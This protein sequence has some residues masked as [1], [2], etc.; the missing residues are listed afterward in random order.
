MLVLWQPFQISW[1][2]AHGLQKAGL[3]LDTYIVQLL[4]K[5]A[6]RM[7]AHEGGKQRR[8]TLASMLS[9]WVMRVGNLPALFKPGPSNLGICLM[10]DSDAR[11]AAYFLAAECT[12]QRVSRCCQCIMTRLPTTRII[13]Q[14]SAMRQTTIA[15]DWTCAVQ[16]IHAE[17]RNAMPTSGICI[18]P[19]MAARMHC[20]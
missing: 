17:Q 18:C 13:S 10:T 8:L 11:K 16:C 5:W 19:D 4:G 1:C 6:I 9:L 12:K 14:P 20:F 7:L 15:I 3:R 2:P